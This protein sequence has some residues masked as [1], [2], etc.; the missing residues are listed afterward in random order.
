MH[1]AGGPGP[2]AVDDLD[3]T[4]RWL[5]TGHAANQLT[6]F[7]VNEQGQLTVHGLSAPTPGPLPTTD[8]ETRGTRAVFPANNGYFTLTYTRL[9]HHLTLLGLQAR[10]R[11]DKPQLNLYSPISSF[12]TPPSPRPFFRPGSRSPCSRRAASRANFSVS[13]FRRAGASLSSGPILMISAS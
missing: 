7:W 6:A 5:E 4:D 8:Q 11:H 2:F 9:V 1:C 10:L 13:F 12:P 3:V